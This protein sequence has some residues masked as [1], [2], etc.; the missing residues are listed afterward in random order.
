MTQYKTILIL[1][2]LFYL[3]YNLNYNV[4]KFTVGLENIELSNKLSLDNMCRNMCKG[5]PALKGCSEIQRNHMTKSLD[6]NKYGVYEQDDGTKK[7]RQCKKHIWGN[8]EDPSCVNEINN[9]LCYLE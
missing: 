9:K 7:Y 2:I 4:N 1:I 6:C 5:I 3:I 8:G